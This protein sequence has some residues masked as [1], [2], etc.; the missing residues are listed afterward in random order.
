MSLWDSNKGLEDYLSDKERIS[1]FVPP[2][3]ARESLSNIIKPRNFTLL[4]FAKDSLKFFTGAYTIISIYKGTDRSELTSERHQLVR[5][6]VE[7]AKKA[8]QILNTEAY[9]VFDKQDNLPN[10]LKYP[11]RALQEAVINSLVHRDF[12]IDQPT[13]ITVF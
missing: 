8:L 1:S 2:L 9:T 7:Q 4:I 12:E 6:I 11:M 5:S 10:Q 13:R 3:A